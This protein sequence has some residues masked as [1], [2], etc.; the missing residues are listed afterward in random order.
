[1]GV[2]KAVGVRE[3][4]GPEA[5][6][7]VEMD[8]PHPGPGQIRVRVHAAAINPT[9]TLFRAGVTSAEFARDRPP[10]YLPGMDVAGVV[11][12]VGGA[13]ADRLLA[14]TP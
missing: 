4:G 3:F 10:P 8:E 9:D 12:E 11:D 14:V 5:L 6:G 7:V 2:V 1:M 13:A